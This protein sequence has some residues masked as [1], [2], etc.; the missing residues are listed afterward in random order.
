VFLLLSF[1][2]LG[3][4]TSAPLLFFIL[5]FNTIFI[6]FNTLSVL[7]IRH[8]LILSTLINSSLFILSLIFLKEATL[9][10]FL[11]FFFN[12]ILTS[13]LLFIYLDFFNKNLLYISDLVEG[14]NTWTL[15]FFFIFPLLSLSG[16]APSLGFFFKFFFLVNSWAYSNFFIFS[17][18]VFSLVY[19][20]V[21]YFQFFKN[22]IF[23]HVKITTFNKIGYK[24]FWKKFK[25]QNFFF[26]LFFG[27]LLIFFFILFLPLTI[28]VFQYTLY[29]F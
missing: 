21:F 17:L 18:I 24:N 4:K 9:N 7:D 5:L 23:S 1:D 29:L 12:Y 3:D 16:A 10:F 15:F 14:L 8:F 11:A 2:L 19:T 28:F 27:L 22:I 6:I 13:F 25:S 26:F 20:I